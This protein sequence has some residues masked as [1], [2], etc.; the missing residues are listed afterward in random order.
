VIALHGTEDMF[1][2]EVEADNW[3][4]GGGGLAADG[5]REIG[6]LLALAGFGEAGVAVG[7]RLSEGAEGKTADEGGAEKRHGTSGEVRSTS[8][9]YHIENVTT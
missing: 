9:H 5:G 6:K 7:Q 2:D 8:R 3:P 1:V 4:G